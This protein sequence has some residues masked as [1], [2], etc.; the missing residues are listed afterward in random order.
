VY[1][2]TPAQEIAA[3]SDN[4]PFD[5][6]VRVRQF[7][8]NYLDSI[9]YIDYYREMN[10]KISEYTKHMDFLIALGGA[11]SGGSGLGILASQWMAIPCGIVTGASIIL[12]AAEKSYDWPG[13]SKKVFDYMQKYSVLYTEYRNLFE[14]VQASRLWN[15]EFERRF[16]ASRERLDDIPLDEF[17]SLN[18]SI[19]ERIQ[20]E[21]EVRENPKSWWKPAPPDAKAD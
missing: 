14:D 8:A 10:N 16:L 11:L 12:S 19:R 20:Q 21:I 5:P 7:Y 2:L 3:V 18:L 15:S 17:P 9:Y 4:P 13:K 6:G 1:S